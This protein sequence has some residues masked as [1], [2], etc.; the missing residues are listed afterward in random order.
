MINKIKTMG[1][2]QGQTEYCR[3]RI[4]NNNNFRGTNEWDLVTI[5]EMVDPCGWDLFSIL[6]NFEETFFVLEGEVTFKSENGLFFSSKE[7]PFV[8]N[9]SHKFKIMRR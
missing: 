2:N 8:S 1:S 4:S 3:W 7:L 5:I 9:W 6:T